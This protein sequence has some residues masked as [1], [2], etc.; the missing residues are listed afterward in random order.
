MLLALL[1]VPLSRSSPR[2]GKYA[3]VT[4]AVLVFAIYYNLSAMAKK[5]VAQG[6]LDAVP[7]I[8]WVQVL[9]GGLL[10]LLLW[11]PTK[12]LRWRRR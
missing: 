10:L 6:V 12:M 2:Q 11:Q 4:S 3:K 1:G 9:L 7:G 8:W 5:W